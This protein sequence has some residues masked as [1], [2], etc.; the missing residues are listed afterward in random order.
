MTVAIKDVG[1]LARELSHQKSKYIFWLGAGVSVTAG[2]PA[3]VG[4]VDRLLDRSWLDAQE[5]SKGPQILEPY[6]SLS[7]TTRLDRL[8]LVRGWALKNISGIRGLKRG[9]EAREP[10]AGK[11]DW[12]AHY[13]TCLAL[14]P[15]EQVRQK[16]IVECIKE[17]KGKL[18]LA[19]L[20]MSQLMVNDFVRIVLTT[21]FD[22]LLLRALQLY[23]EIP[24]IIDADSTHTLMI[25]SMFLQVAY[26]HGRLTSYR[27]RH[28]ERELHKS[29]PDLE[30]FI[31][32]S[33]KDHGLVVVG[34]R[35]GDEAPMKILTRALRR[36][37]A[38]PG[39][40]LFWVSYE[41]DFE[42]LSEDAQKI[43][44]MKD[45]YWLPGW[46]AD[47]F[48]GQ[49]CASAGI[50]LSLPDF[51]ADPRKFAKRL[52]SILPEGA[53]GPWNELQE[54][55]P[56]V[57]ATGD[58]L[59]NPAGEDRVSPTSSERATSIPETRKP[60]GKG[61]FPPARDAVASP[62]LETPEQGMDR[63]RRATE[64]DPKN[65]EVFFEWGN[66]LASVGQYEE[67]IEKYR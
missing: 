29:M 10:G 59:S 37:G 17:G 61:T 5:P 3:G 60:D 36:R 19:H 46:D 55:G 1:Y 38:G 50:G 7:E 2:I 23:F 41:K 63:F 65:S 15:G 53:R 9:K 22:D 44:R 33:M 64:T 18:N 8:K 40:G 49:L 26:L 54:P 27:Q 11:V 25:D 52:G 13:S 67:A 56:D 16:F 58:E 42:K 21:N 4:I 35:G 28:T 30:S 51:L 43:L 20:L 6:S 24:S 12:G 47:R 32:S 66:A 45:T 57:V 14:L 34:Y 31:V 62:S 39:G 48:F